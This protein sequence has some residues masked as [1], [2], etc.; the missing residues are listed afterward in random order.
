MIDSERLVVFS[1]EATLYS[2]MSVCQSV[3]YPNPPASQNQSFNLHH[4][5]QQHLHY[6]LLLHLCHHLH[7]HIHC[8][9]SPPSCFELVTFQLFSLSLIRPKF[10]NIGNCQAP[11]QSQGQVVLQRV[12]PISLKSSILNGK[13]SRFR[14]IGT[15]SGN[16][17]QF[18]RQF[19]FRNSWGMTKKQKSF[20]FKKKLYIRVCYGTK[21]IF[22]HIFCKNRPWGTPQ[23]P[24]KQ[25]FFNVGVKLR[26]Q[27]SAHFQIIF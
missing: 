5:N 3:S 26:K 24:Q 1:R 9:L 11:V 17:R 20:F 22:Q 6:K 25:F 2:Q 18:R 14:Q 7:H 16:L 10:R 15:H 13:I 27:I 4:H 21:H 19:Y 12:S 8:H 23:A